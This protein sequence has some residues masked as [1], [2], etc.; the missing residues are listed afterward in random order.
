MRHINP[1]KAGLSVGSVLGIWHFI[2]VSLVAVGWA[3]PVLDFILELHFIQLQFGLAPFALG[4][5]VTLVAVTFATGV[6]FGCVFAVVW[7]WLSL[8]TRAPV[9]LVKSRGLREA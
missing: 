6:I 5:A 3:K 4:T 8:E 2:W 1:T 7:N 9:L